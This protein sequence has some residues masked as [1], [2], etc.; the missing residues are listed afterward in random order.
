MN[1]HEWLIGAGSG[2]T[3]DEGWCGIG[4]GTGGSGI[5]G[6]VEEALVKEAI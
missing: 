6:G 5:K 4:G 2:G 1:K 3:T